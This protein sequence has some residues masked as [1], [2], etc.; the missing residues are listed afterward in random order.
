LS[1]AAELVADGALESHVEPTGAREVASLGVSFNRMTGRLR[2][3]ITRLAAE[4]AQAEAILASMVD[5]VLVVNREGDIILINASAETLFDLHAA[6]V[7]GRTMD[8]AL[9]HFELGPLLAQAMEAGVPLKHEI[10]LTHPAAH[11]VEVHLAPVDVE[12]QR[13]GTVIVLYDVT[14][15]RHMEQ[16]HRDFVAN[17]SHELRT[18]VASIRAMAETILMMQGD[19]P[20]QA[21]EFLN[22]IITES[23]RFTEL[24]D[25]LLNLARLEAGHRMVNPLPIDICEV[26]RHAAKRVVGPVT[27]KGQTLT[28]DLPP[29]LEAVLDRDAL[30]QVL[31]NLV[32][33]ARK[34]SPEKAA[35]TV[36]ATLDRGVRIQVS[37]TGMGIPEAELE[38][39]FERFYRVD[40]GRARAGGTGL[41]L[42]IV[43]Q[44]VELQGGRILVE[45]TLGEGTTFTVIL[46]QTPPDMEQ[47]P[48]DEPPTEE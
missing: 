40:R 14:Q 21:E 27:E 18:P 5:G 2:E 25:D 38:R 3:T 16:M 30:V 42:A 9:L 29:R 46:P 32:D 43:R 8:E 13:L 17:V 20:Q 44:L 39:I 22:T 47:T 24:L 11:V 36:R 12:E 15:Q 41:G 7:I 26:I 34:Y 48:P 45:S 31:V 33:N 1:A 10:T 35:I 28:L 4:R 37:D 23:D 19:D 6:E